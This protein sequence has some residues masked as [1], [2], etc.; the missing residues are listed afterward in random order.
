[1]KEDQESQRAAVFHVIQC[2]RLKITVIK[3]LRLIFKMKFS[4]YPKWIKSSYWCK[5]Y[6]QCRKAGKHAD[7]KFYD[8]T[9]M[10]IV[11]RIHCQFEYLAMICKRDDRIRYMLNI[12][13]STCK[14]MNERRTQSQLRRNLLE[15]RGKLTV[16]TDFTKQMILSI[17]PLRKKT[18]YLLL[19]SRRNAENSKRRRT[20]K[21]RRHL[22]HRKSAPMS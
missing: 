8:V 6:L 7:A 5:L 3:I 11:L 21:V 16:W 20:F 9:A 22:Q 10:F 15:H 2:S 12:T 14:E 4:E 1:M 13:I 19:E 18:T 17:N